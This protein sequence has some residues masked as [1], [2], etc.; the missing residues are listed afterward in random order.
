VMCAKL[1]KFAALQP[2]STARWALIH[3]DIFDA[4]RCQ[5]CIIVWTGEHKY[6][7]TYWVRRRACP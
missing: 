1:F 4:D 3:R 6:P 5:I 2:E 7:F